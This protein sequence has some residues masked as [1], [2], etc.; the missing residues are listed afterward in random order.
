PAEPGRQ[1]SVNLSA[2]V[3]RP[4]RLGDAGRSPEGCGSLCW[5]PCA[6]R[7]GWPTDTVGPWGERLPVPTRRT[8]VSP[9]PLEEPPASAILPGVDAPARQRGSRPYWPG[10]RRPSA[11][12]D[13]HI[14]R[15]PE[16]RK[17]TPD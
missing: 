8:S 7:R 1:W 14:Y 2:V 12:P 16:L 15:S 13:G 9:R 11:L 3:A 4:H 10:W 5:G 6:P 17:S